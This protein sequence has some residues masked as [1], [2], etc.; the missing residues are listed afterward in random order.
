MVREQFCEAA[1]NMKARYLRNGRPD[2]AAAMEVRATREF[3]C[4][5]TA[6]Q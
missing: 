4:S 3:G 2:L 1:S 5:A 6:V